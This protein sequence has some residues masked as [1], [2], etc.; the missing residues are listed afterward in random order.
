MTRNDYIRQDRIDYPRLF[1]KE[2]ILD[3]VLSSEQYHIRSY[4]IALRSEEYYTF[5][6]R[7][8]FCRY[9][10]KRKKNVLGARLGFFIPAGCFDRGLKISHYG[11]VIVNPVARIGKN[12]TIHGNCCIGSRR[13]DAPEDAPKIGN[14]VNIGQGAQ[15]LGGISI[16]DDVVI[17]AGAIVLNSV[18]RAGSIAVGVPASTVR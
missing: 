2:W 3:K 15:I 5:V 8:S 18:N 4:L 14:N 1:S 6:K 9:Y 17:G 13:E 10:W 12:C 16:A 7:C 11:S